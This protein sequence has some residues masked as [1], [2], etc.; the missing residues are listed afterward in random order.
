[1]I[2]KSVLDIESAEV[3]NLWNESLG[4]R[5][6]MRKELWI[7]NTLQDKN[8]LSEASIAI[9]ENERLVGFVV[10]KKYQE[11]LP[12]NMPKDV[13]W[14]QC[15]LVSESER[16]SGIGTKL[17]NHAEQVFRFLNLKEI[18][19]GRD[20]L[21]YFPGI[22]FEDGSAIDFFKK[23][24][25]SRESVEIDLIRSVKGA[26]KYE[27]TNDENC[28]RI[29]TKEDMPELLSLLVMSF[30]GRWHY[31]ALHYNRKSQK[32][33]EFLGFYLEGKL[34][35]FCRLN[36]HHSPIIAQNVYWSPLFQSPTGG[37]GPLGINRSIRGKRYGIDLV[38][39]AANEL[40][41]RGVDQIIIDWTQLEQFYG[42]L[43]F[44]PWRKYQAMSKPL[45]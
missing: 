7:Q 36:D 38:K 13:G 16:N 32:G 33:R 31:E 40:M 10:C 2:I 4:S 22:P 1:M 23:R 11:Q 26:A 21:H 18:R 25:Y 37:I 12:A 39:A 44:E 15:L 42:K 30:P 28:Y 45:G 19:L 24:G 41:N 34:Q 43:G 5:F 27:L 17:L 3:V 8:V 9:I 29:L 35:G 6:P 14:I 20:P